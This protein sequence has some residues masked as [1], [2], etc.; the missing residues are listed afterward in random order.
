[1]RRADQFYGREG[2]KRASHDKDVNQLPLKNSEI[3]RK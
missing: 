1:M 2:E 3:L